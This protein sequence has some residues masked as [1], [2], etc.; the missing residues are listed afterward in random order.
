MPTVTWTV[1]DTEEGVDLDDWSIGPQDIG[2]GPDGWSVAKHRLVGGKR[3]G[4]TVIQVDNGRMRFEI[5]PTRGMGIRQCAAG[6]AVLGWKSP[7]RGPVHPGFVPLS[8]P[9]GLGWLEGFEELLVRCGL[10]SNGAPEFGENGVLKFPLHGHIA[11]LPAHRVTVSVDTESGRISVQGEVDETRFLFH[12]LRLHCT[13]STTFGETE[14]TVKDRVENR[15]ARPDEF[16]LLYH[17]NVGAPLLDAGSRLVVPAKTVVPRDARAAEGVANWSIYHGEQPGFAEQVYFLDLAGDAE[18][19]TCVL[20]K[21]AAGKQGVQLTFNR[22][23]L[24]CFTQWKNTGATDDGYV[25]G[26]EPG[27]NLPNPRSFEGE[28]GR[29]V[30]LEP[31]EEYHIDLALAW[32]LDPDAV[33]AAEGAVQKLH[34]DGE[35]HVFDAPQPGWCAGA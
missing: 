2:G 33:T 1:L 29:A 27:T 6:D 5:V 15:S 3:H 11:N 30:P 24:P 10:R 13:V 21:N 19:Q 16:Q 32:L 31:G 20:L 14:L 34:P 18:N 22:D 7:V 26:I 25:T 28:Q 35:P 9:S 4:V 17:V 12:N 23:Q 8:E